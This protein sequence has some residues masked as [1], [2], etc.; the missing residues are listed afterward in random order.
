MKIVVCFLALLLAFSCTKPV[1]KKASESVFTKLD[2]GETGIAFQNTITLQE[3]FDVF[4]YRNFYNGGGVAL[5]DINNDGLTDVFF[6][7]N[8]ENN[9]LYLNKGNWKFEDITEKAGING[10][11]VWSTGVSMADVNGDGLLDIYVCNSGDPNGDNRENE[12]F[13]NNG[14]LTFT[15]KAAEMGLA[16]KGFSTHSVFFDYDNDGDLDCYILN[17]SF[18]PISTLGYR[19]LRDVRDELGGDKLM[20]NDNGVFT[21]VS[22]AAGIYGSVIGF[23]LG[24]TVGDINDDN[25][26]DIYVSNDFYERD[27][28]YINNRDGTFSEKITDLMGHI[29]MFSMGADMADVN[30]DGYPDIFSTDMLPEDDERLKKLT[31]FETYDVY[32]LRLR[33]SYYHQFMRNMLQLNRGDGTFAEVGQMAGVAATDWSW[34]ALMADFDN[35]GNKELFVCNGI[36][37][38]V[39]DQDFIEYMGS[40]ET[41][42]EAFLGKKIDFTKF[43]EGMTSTK[44]SNYLFKRNNSWQFQNVSAQWGLNEPSFSNGAAYGDLDNDGD[45]DLVVNNLNM[46]AFVYRNE[47]LEHS[48]TGD[49]WL[50]ISFKGNEK[51]TFGIGA[52][53]KAYSGSN[54]FYYENMPMR[55]FQ[56]SMD[57]KMVIGTGSADKID[58]VSITWPDGKVEWMKAVTT[59][60]VVKADYANAS[61]AV[62]HTNPSEQGLLVELPDAPANHRENEYS[63]F[64][65]ERLI[66]H[67]LSSQGPAFAVGDVNGDG[68]DDM[69]QGGAMGQ[70]GTLLIQDASGKFKNLR[71]PLFDVDSTA[72]DVDALFFDADGDKDLDL[73]VVTGGTEFANQAASLKDRLYLNQSKGGAIAWTKSDGLP[74]IFQTGSCVTAADIDHDGDQDLFVGTR[75]IPGYYGDPPGQYI[76]LNDGKGKFSDATASWAPALSRLGMV[77]DAEWADVDGDGW[78][79]LVVVGE[80]MPVTVFKNDGKGLTLTDHVSNGFD[81]SDGW[82]NEVKVQDINGDKKPDLILGNLGWNS[83][84]RPSKEEPVSLYIADFDNNGSI[85]PIY[86]YQRGG[87]TYPYAL[88]QDLLKQIPSLKKKFLYYKDYA[89]KT[90]EEVFSPEQLQKAKILRFYEPSN[91]I[92]LN[93]GGVKFEMKQLPPE[94]QVAPVYAI[95]PMDLNGDDNQDLVI[96][97]NFFP[98][99]PEIGRYDDM[100]GLVLTGDGKGNFKPLSAAASGLKVGGEVK[101]IEIVRTRKGVDLAVARNNESLKL[102][103]VRKQK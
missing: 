58:S 16:D 30:N 60:Q 95:L 63:E 98:V 18:K 62:S 48:K 99:K 9:R 71:T 37:R 64:N 65:R 103:G 72:E 53:V 20:R 40:S 51:N 100:R 28:L 32:Q 50:G 34:G 22:E 45:L 92:A 61:K 80:W 76:L 19:N 73:Y 43:V 14:D 7:S 57:Y 93:Q 83:R 74:D 4:R 90:I 41:I 77:T 39:T 75:V 97:G 102:Y 69:F 31:A 10:S 38:D 101:D 23:G 3:D 49:H 87:K 67:M 33:N 42:R 21:D 5:G 13:I 29:S 8:M 56:S 96:A 11:K 36:N 1:E 79:D 81:K 2:G 91:S 82:W 88:R 15:D 78:H 26:M 86:T 55:G 35:D 70:S 66:F 25:W 6:T 44:L 47:T 59:N 89:G 46:P 85:D 52:K 17:N 27:Y 12:L 54:I 94:A 84:F 24:V 68:L